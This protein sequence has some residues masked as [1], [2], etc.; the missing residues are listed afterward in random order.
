MARFAPHP[1]GLTL[2]VKVCPAN[3]KIP[4][5]FVDIV[6]LL[7]VLKN[8]ELATDLALIVGR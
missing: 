1:V 2:S 8:A 7:G 3:P 4:T 5:C 6:D